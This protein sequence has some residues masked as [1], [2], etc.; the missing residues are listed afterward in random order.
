MAM[1]MNAEAV[2]IARRDHMGIFLKLA[3]GDPAFDRMVAFVSKQ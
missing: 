2:Q 3:P 1:A